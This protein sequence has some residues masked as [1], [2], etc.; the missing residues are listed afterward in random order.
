MIDVLAQDY[1]IALTRE[2]QTLLGLWRLVR[3][4]RF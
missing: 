3:N 1:S 4:S 2:G